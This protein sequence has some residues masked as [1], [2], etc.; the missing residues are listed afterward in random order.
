M[1]EKLELVTHSMGMLKFKTPT[2]GERERLLAHAK[3]V[4]EFGEKGAALLAQAKRRVLPMPSLWDDEDPALTTQEDD[5]GEGAKTK[6]DRLTSEE[7][8]ALKNL[9]ALLNSTK[10]IEDLKSLASK[11]GHLAEKSH[12]DRTG[13][14]AQSGLRTLEMP[15]LWD[16]DDKGPQTQSADGV[17]PM[18]D[19]D[20]TPGFMVGVEHETADDGTLVMPDPWEDDDGD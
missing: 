14:A 12:E 3:A 15:P 6:A 13:P 19:Q 10:T 8:D 11:L 1:T 18:P 7:L 17:L 9:A 5:E 16:E 20:K 2:A 4:E